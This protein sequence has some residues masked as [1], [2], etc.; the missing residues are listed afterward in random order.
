ME[1]WPNYEVYRIHELE[2]ALENIDET[3]NKK[4]ADHIRMLIEKG[5]YKDPAEL[6]ASEPPVVA[7][8]TRILLGIGVSLLMFWFAYKKFLNDDNSGFILFL[9]IGIITSINVVM[10]LWLSNKMETK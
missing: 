1:N 3:N 7:S 9:A 4:E 6:E 2:K 10:R 5:G 8:N